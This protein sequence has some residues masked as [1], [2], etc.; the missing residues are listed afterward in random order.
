MKHLPQSLTAV[1]LCAALASCHTSKQAGAQ[2][3]INEHHE[4]KAAMVSAPTKKLVP[5]EPIATRSPEPASEPTPT[6]VGSQQALA[7]ALQ[8]ALKDPLLQTSQVGICVYDLTDDCPIF[9]HGHQQRLRPA[10]TMKLVTAI[11]AMRT[12]GVDYRYRT[13]LLATDSIDQTN[14]TLCGNLYI[15]G[16]MDPILSSSDLRQLVADLAK[17]GVKQIKGDVCFD[18]SFKEE[19]EAGWGWCWDDD[20][21][22]M[23]AFLLSGKGKGAFRDAFL[24]QLRHKGIRLSGTAKLAHIPANAQCIAECTHTLDQVLTT[25]LKESD[26]QMAESIF[27]QTAAYSGKRG[28]GRKEAARLTQQLLDSLGIGSR[29]YEIADGSGLSLYNY[30]TPELL[31][32]LLRYAYKDGNIYDHLLPALPIAAKDGTLSKRMH[33]TRAAGNVCAKTGTLTGVSALAGYL[34]ASNGHRLAFAIINQGIPSATAGRNFQDR[35]CQIMAECGG[36]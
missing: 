14:G 31:V 5:V 4:P 11:T 23:D 29:H 30:L 3:S 22:P 9:L 26:N 18:A 15:R 35:L 6:A 33:G 16:C 21:P 1:L 28:A 13:L 2:Q 27:Y 34:T 12:L 32:T 19:S 36:E 7:T 20:N 10:S 8:Q 25:T 17:A 24:Q